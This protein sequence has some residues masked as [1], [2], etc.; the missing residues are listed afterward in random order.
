MHIEDIQLSAE[1]RCFYEEKFDSAVIPFDHVEIA[2][3]IGEGKRFEHCICC[4][5]LTHPHQECLGLF[6]KLCW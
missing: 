5:F 2:D 3:T 1:E 4:P 6:A